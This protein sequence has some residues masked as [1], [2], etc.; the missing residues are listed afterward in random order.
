[1]LAEAKVDDVLTYALFPQVGLKFLANRNNRDAFEPAPTGL[2]PAPAGKAPDGPATYTVEVEGA[3]YVVAVSAG[4]E[5]TQ[6]EAKGATSIA[7]TKAV[8]IG[9]GEPL[10]APLAGTIVEVRADAGQS[11]SEGDVVVI[12]E[13]MKMETEVR[14]TKAGTVSQ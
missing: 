9:E 2:E 5:I 12:L 11:V 4:G 8:A 10:G 3:K 14:A 6:I 1:T 13:A 7:P